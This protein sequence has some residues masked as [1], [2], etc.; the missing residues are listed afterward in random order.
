MALIAI[1]I[2]VLVFVM[3]GMIEI[4]KLE[5]PYNG[6]NMIVLGIIAMVSSSFFG[7]AMLIIGGVYW[8]AEESKKKL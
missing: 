2:T 3:L 5:I 6:T 4:Q 8:F 1:G 7:G